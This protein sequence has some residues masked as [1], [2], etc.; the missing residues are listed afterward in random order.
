MIY[1]GVVM[2]TKKIHY[3]WFGGNEKPDI[4]QK[5]IESWRKFCPDYEIIEWNESNFNVHHCKYVSQAYKHKK[6]AF[7]S[8]Y[9]RFKI[10]SEQGG[11]YLDTDVEIIKSIAEL[12]DAFVGFES[13]SSVNSGLIRGADIGDE[14]CSLML[15][16]Y[17]N[18]FFVLE[19]GELN[20]KTVCE[21]ETALLVEKG[22]ILNGERQVVSGTTVFPVE[23]FCPKDY[24]TEKLTITENTH[25]IHHYASSWYSEENKLQYKL[26]KRYRKF[27][28]KRI[29]DILATFFAKIKHQGLGKAL[30]WVFKRRKKK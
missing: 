28:P 13:K 12:P 15:E 4:V 21:R 3:C 8:D 14:I 25:C 9:A 27:M 19:D 11:V 7:V 22:L 29:A 5:C 26:Q 2:K 30:K 24:I 1:K 17:N 10:L 23:Y 16:R 18:D 6:Y 20:L